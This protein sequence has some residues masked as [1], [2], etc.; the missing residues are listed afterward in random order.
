MV[1]RHTARFKSRR[2]RVARQSRSVYRY[3]CNFVTAVRRKVNGRGCLCIVAVTSAR[4]DYGICIRDRRQGIGA[5]LPGRR[6]LQVPARALLDDYLF[7]SAY[8]RAVGGGRR[9]PAKEF[10]ACFAGVHQRNIIAVDGVAR[11]VVFRARRALQAMI[12]NGKACVHQRERDNIFPARSQRHALAAV[13]LRQ[14]NAVRLQQAVQHVFIRRYGKGLRLR[15]NGGGGMQRC[16]VVNILHRILHISQRGVNECN[17]ILGR[18]RL[19]REAL[20]KRVHRVPGILARRSNGFFQHRAAHDAVACHRRCN[21]MHHAVRVRIDVMDGIGRVPICFPLC[22]NRSI[23]NNRSVHVKRRGS[24]L[25]LVPALERIALA[26][27]RGGLRRLALFHGNGTILRAVVVNQ[28]YRLFR[29]GPLGVKHQV[30]AGHCC[31]AVRVA[32]QLGVVVPA[33]KRI[34]AVQAGRTL[35]SI[36]ILGAVDGRAE[37]DVGFGLQYRIVV[38]VFDAVFR[39][40]VVEAV[41]ILA[42]LFTAALIPA[43]RIDLGIT[44]N[45]LRT[46]IVTIYILAVSCFNCV[47]GAVRVFQPIF[48]ASVVAVRG[49]LRLVRHRVVVTGIRIAHKVG[50]QFKPLCLIAAA[51]CV[52]NIWLRITS[53]C[54]TGRRNILIDRPQC[55]NILS[56]YYIFNFV[57]FARI[58]ASIDLNFRIGIIEIKH[59]RVFNQVIIR[60]HNRGTVRFHGRTGAIDKRAV[61]NRL[62]STRRRNGLARFCRTHHGRI[63]HI[64]SGVGAVVP[65]LLHIYDRVIH[66]L[67]SPLGINRFIFGHYN[68][69]L[70]RLGALGVQIPSVKGVALPG[71]ERTAC[72]C[73]RILFVASRCMRMLFQSQLTAAVVMPPMT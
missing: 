14:F 33:R 29:R 17:H 25:V 65:H 60:V 43:G 40:V 3:S 51:P 44:V 49:P 71:G 12:C 28:R 57:V 66:V 68:S 1:H 48:H 70:R 62:S 46:Q 64:V 53:T 73:I 32:R 45:R 19:E 72:C 36:I 61:C 31:E 50:R 30:G 34:L 16:A 41:D 15:R 22:V 6:E 55:G 8:M 38:A 26:L 7:I 24:G 2:Q 67:R 18:R 11:G 35:R 13:R 42:V 20:G 4:V 23:R 37:S 39:P 56:D 52:K 9:R 58:C 69:G 21:I 10:I 27:R 63:I 5:Q 47:A 59:N 54:G